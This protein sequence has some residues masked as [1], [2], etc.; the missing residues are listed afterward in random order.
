MIMS[1]ITRNLTL[2]CSLRDSG[3]AKEIDV[4]EGLY[5]IGIG[6]KDIDAIQ[7]NRREIHVTFKNREAKTVATAMDIKVNGHSVKMCDVENNTTNVTLKDIP[8]Q[9]S[10]QVVNAYLTGYATVLNEIS[11]GYVRMPDGTKTNIRNGIRYI[12]V[13]DIKEPIP[14]APIIAGFHGRLSY[15]GQPCNIC[16]LT[17]HPWWRCP[18]KGVRKCYTCGS[19]DHIVSQCTGRDNKNEKEKVIEKDEDEHI[20]KDEQKSATTEEDTKKPDTILTGGSIAKGIST[21]MKTAVPACQSGAKIEHVPGLLQKTGDNEEI[22]YVVMQVGANNIVYS[23]EAPDVCLDKYDRM[24]DEVHKKYPSSIIVASSVTPVH[25][26]TGKNSKMQSKI[27]KTNKLIN[28]MC[29][30]KDF[31]TFV[32]N[33]KVLLCSDGKT[34]PKDYSSNDTKGVHLSLHGSAKVAR[35]IMDTLKG[36]EMDDATFQTPP[37]NKRKERGSSST[38]TSA[39]KQP[40]TKSKKLGSYS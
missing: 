34:S 10:D 4:L 1:V 30:S 13:V 32:D 35:N 11:H 14:S 26:S 2:K 9:V 39:E 27:T 17:D 21:I 25:P 29:K 18:L 31:T 28:M 8:I 36:I 6:E 38:P 40:E 3:Y 24:V 33:D 37:T 7:I 23:N 15:Q 12:S 19:T 16:K 20:E 22:K 5:H